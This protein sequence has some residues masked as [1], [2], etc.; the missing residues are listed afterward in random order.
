M[1]VLKFT[2]L[3]DLEGTLKGHLVLL[4][5]NERGHL[6]LDHIAQS[7]AQSD[8]NVSRDW[9]SISSWTLP[10]VVFAFAVIKKCQLTFSL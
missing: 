1:N 5:C 6:Q 2:E 10:R 9:T 7:L 8:S 4:P 3:F